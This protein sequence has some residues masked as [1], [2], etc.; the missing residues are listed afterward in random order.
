MRRREFIGSL[1]AMPA[2]MACDSAKAAT[3]IEPRH[4]LCVLGPDGWLSSVGPIVASF[5]HGFELDTEYSLH[6]SDARMP[7]AFDASFDRVSPSQDDSDLEHIRNHGS[8]AYV[9]SP[10][11]TAE[12][13]IHVSMQA[14]ALTAKL[15]SAGGGAAKSDSAGIA[16]GRDH[17]LHLADSATKDPATQLAALHA[18]WVR[19]PIAA[20]PLLLYSCGMHLLGLADIECTRAASE[21]ESVDLLDSLAL[22]TLAIP[23]PRTE[24]RLT[25]QG[26]ELEIQHL[27]CTRYAE[28]DFHFN[29]YGYIRVAGSKPAR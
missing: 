23:L 28:D 11:M 2:A 8:V 17:W 15:L 12:T 3:L 1:I 14:L 5:G 4:V 9:L 27:E 26:R 10:P 20:G 24:T 19:R 25:H 16:H 13:A 22:R 21:R 7:V 29:P 18:A 6:E